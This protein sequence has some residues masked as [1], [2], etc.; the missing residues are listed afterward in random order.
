MESVLVPIRRL[1]DIGSDGERSSSFTHIVRLLFKQR[2][3]CLL[4]TYCLSK[5]LDKERLSSLY[6]RVRQL[7]F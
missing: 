5:D 2:E 4:F 7:R 6:L 1:F 3:Y